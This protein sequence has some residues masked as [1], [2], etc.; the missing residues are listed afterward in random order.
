M[1]TETERK[2]FEIKSAQRFGVPY[3][4]YTKSDSDAIYL[5]RSILDHNPNVSYELGWNAEK[6]LYCCRLYR[7]KDTFIY[8]HS[9]ET[10]ALAICKA[11]DRGIVLGMV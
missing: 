11:I 6:K 7:V 9:G 10:M 2:E 1:M 3:K 5:L 8:N 4:G